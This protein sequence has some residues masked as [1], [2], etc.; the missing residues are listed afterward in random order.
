MK[1]DVLETSDISN[2]VELLEDGVLLERFRYDKSDIENIEI[3]QLYGIPSEDAKVWTRSDSDCDDG[4][5]CGKYVTDLLTENSISESDARLFANKCGEFDDEYG[6]TKD[7]VG[8]FL[9]NL[10]LD[11]SREYNLSLK[12][13]CE[14]LD[15]NEKIICEVSSISLYYPE[16]ADFPCLS[17][18]RF[19]QIIGIDETSPENITVIV[20]DPFESVGG[21]VVNADV[22]MS[23]W[24]TSNYY[25]VFAK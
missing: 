1:Y 21:T 14:S 4:I 20:N 23:A 2:T 5:L 22:F 18:D 11:I 16:A 15:N 24:K 6:F 8:E 7:G 17:A 25:A 9:K 13:L 3:S 19:V 12:D 10:G